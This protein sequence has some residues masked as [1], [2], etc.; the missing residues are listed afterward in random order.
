MKL[1]RDLRP[2]PLTDV[3]PLGRPGQLVMTMHTSQWDAMLAAAYQAG[4]ILLEL[5]DDEKPIAA[6]R[7]G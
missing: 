1:A 2:F 6:Y 3:L 4:F 5:D 7:K